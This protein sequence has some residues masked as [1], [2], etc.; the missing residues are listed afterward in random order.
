MNKQSFYLKYPHFDWKFY[1]NHYED[2]KHA[3]IDNEDKAI[4]HYVKYGHKELRRTHKIV[5]VT[6]EITSISFEDILKMTPQLQISNSLI[7]LYPQIITKFKIFNIK[8][9]DNIFEPAIFFGIYNDLDIERVYKHK[10]ISFIIWGG[11]DM[12]PKN[13]HSKQTVYEIKKIKN[14]I[15][16]SISNCIYKSLLKYNI[17]SIKIDMDLVN[18]TIFKPSLQCV[19]KDTIFIYNGLTPG[20]EYIYGIKYYMRVLK[21]IPQFKV[22][23]SN[24]LNV[25]NNKMPMIYS[26]CF[27]ALRLTDHDGNANMVQECK[28]M[29]IPVIHNHSDYGLK[30][31]NANQI[32]KHIINVSLS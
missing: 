24:V 28:A 32:I 2:L 20:K 10:N 5:E 22:I 4:E 21:K 26:K 27:I 29:N 12:N 8:K 25:S 30:W 3:N 6:N 15:H 16:V 11:E 17:K 7:H 23:Y 1:I 19:K 14:C 13:N 18:Y 31:K 9:Y